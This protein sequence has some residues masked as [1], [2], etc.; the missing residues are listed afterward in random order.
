MGN[1]SDIN[2]FNFGPAFHRVP[3][4]TGRPGKSKKKFHAWKNHGIWKKMEKS[5]NF[6]CLTV[7]FLATGDLSFYYCFKMHVWSTTGPALV[8]DIL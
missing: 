1:T 6:V 8:P 4:S 5:W 3:T 2:Y 7:C